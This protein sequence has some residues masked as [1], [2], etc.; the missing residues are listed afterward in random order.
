VGLSEMADLFPF[1][2]SFGDRRKLAEAATLALEPEVLILDEPTT[3]QDHR[4]RYQLADLAKRF[5]DEQG[6]TVLMI[7]H[8]VDLIAHYANR[9]IVL[10]NGQVLLDG[11]TAEVFTH[12]EELR[13][14]FVVPPVATQ[15]AMKLTSLG[16]PPDIIT[17]DKLYAL[18]GS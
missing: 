9:L 2:L 13:R 15:L 7:T 16:I 8:D 11:P 17:L 5:H 12:V 3:A 18:L 6:G 10:Y 1:R 14:S 4:G